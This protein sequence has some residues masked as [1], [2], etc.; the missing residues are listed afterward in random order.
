MEEAL[1]AQQDAREMHAAIHLRVDGLSPWE[2]SEIGEHALLSPS[3]PEYAHEHFSPW[4]KHP[5]S[6]N[7]HQGDCKRR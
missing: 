6:E 7:M 5:K 1:I 3:S 2:E 4:C